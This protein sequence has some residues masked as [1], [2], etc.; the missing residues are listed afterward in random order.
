MRTFWQ[1]GPQSKRKPAPPWRWRAAVLLAVSLAVVAIGYLVL[2]W[3]PARSVP[4]GIDPAEAT[5]LR[6]A[7]RTSYVQFV[8]ALALAAGLLFTYLNLKAAR[9]A[10]LTERFSKAAEMLGHDKKE[11]RLGAVYALE[12]IARDSRADHWTVMELLS[13]FVRENAAWKDA[14]SEPEKHSGGGRAFAGRPRLKADIQAAMTVISRR[15]WRDHELDSLSLVNTDLRGALLR[16]AQLEGVNLA[17]A[18]LEHADL[19][20]ACLRFA[21]L[22]YATLSRADLEWADLRGAHMDHAVV[23]ANLE[24]ADL[25]DADL[26]SA[27]ISATDLDEADLRG[28]RLEVAHAKRAQFGSAN[29]TGANFLTAD[30]TGASLLHVVG[31]TPDDL[32][33]ATMDETTRLPKGFVRPTVPTGG[34]DT[35]TS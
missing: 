8:G 34:G 18:H 16:R 13:A 32:R 6:I 2:V 30:L 17:G 12:R 22:E 27:D 10:K 35:S 7:A 28:A 5:Q 9:E 33:Q 24:G 15:S 21:N 23:Q 4:S 25:R 31:L 11:V 3:G 29:V 20:H 14:E 1:G 19:S 26:Y